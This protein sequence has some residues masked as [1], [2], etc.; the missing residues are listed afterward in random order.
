MRHWAG[1][2]GERFQFYLPLRK[3]E[4][5]NDGYYF[6]GKANGVREVHAQKLGSMIHAEAPYPMVDHVW[7]A[8]LTGTSSLFATKIML[9]LGYDEVLLAGC[10]LDDSGRY[11]DAPWNKGCDLNPMSLKEWEEFLPIFNGRVKSMSGRTRELLGG[12]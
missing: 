8:P 3:D 1:C 5:G 2:H 9:A 7:E 10:P 11:Y 6:R 12:L 4:F